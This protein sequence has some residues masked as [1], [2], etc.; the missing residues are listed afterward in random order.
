MTFILIFVG[1]L[2]TSTGSGLA[3]PDWPLA[4]GRLVPP[5]WIG[6]IRFEYSHRVM[7]GTVAVLTFALAG[8]CWFAEP[9]RWVRNLAIGAFGLVIV[10][11]LLGALNVVFLLPL[12]VTVAHAATAQLFFCLMVGLVMFTNPSW[13]VMP[14]AR[15][16]DDVRPTLRTL[17][18]ITTAVIYI[19]ILIGALMR[20]LGAGLAIPDFPLSYGQLVP[21]G[22]SLPIT[23]NF[24]H[25][26][27]ALAVTILA[28]WTFAR[29]ARRYRD[30]PR[31]MRP[32]VGLLVL[33]ALQVT[34]GAL[35]IWTHRAVLPTT[36]HV[37]TGAAVLA[38]AFAL[39]IRTWRPTRAHSAMEAIPVRGS[40][41][42]DRAMARTRVA[43]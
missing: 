20:N 2:V 12:G 18:T 38:T 41:P 25:R 1:G 17:A 22:W 19:Q 14:R 24:A 8:W 15:I 4:F 43:S 36:A 37:A 11:A 31:L 23:V 27:G 10:Q 29:I 40:Y 6:G 35:T 9:R 32:A 16:A 5:H 33:V 21:P 26:C 39:T 34:L 30:E 42:R 28:V 13:T 7:A 3:V